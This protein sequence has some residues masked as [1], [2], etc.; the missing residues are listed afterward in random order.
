MQQIT[1]GSQLTSEDKVNLM[2]DRFVHVTT[3]FAQQIFIPSKNKYE[4]RPIRMSDGQYRTLTKQHVKEHLMGTQT[5]GLYTTNQNQ[6]AKWLCLDVDS[7]DKDLVLRLAQGV[8]KHFGEGSY[9]IEF[10]GSRGYHIWI[11]FDQPKPV[12]QV[13][14][15]GRLLTKDVRIEIYPKQAAIDGVGNLVKIPLGIQKKTDARCWFVDKDFTPYENQ[16]DAL[17]NVRL[18]TYL[19]Y[20]PEEPK[21]T[22]RVVDVGLPCFENMMEQGLEEGVRDIGLFKLGCFYRKNG[23]PHDMALTLAHMVNDKSSPPLSDELVEEKIRSAYNRDYS[24]F[25]CQEQTLDPYCSSSCKFFA[26]KALARN[27]TVEELSKRIG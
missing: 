23:I 7:M 15:L 26:S 12:R 13:V 25:P 22:I 24:H 8:E 18:I 21:K 6:T 10:S 1:S 27:L 16:W 11:F 5:L 17:R 19:G 3:P 14:A 4:F 2:W 20:F 9:L